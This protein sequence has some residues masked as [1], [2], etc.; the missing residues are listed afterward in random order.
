M[1]DGTDG[2][3]LGAAVPAVIR[4]SFGELLT[5]A[6]KGVRTEHGGEPIWSG[7]QRSNLGNNDFAAECHGRGA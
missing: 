4:N 6:S 2:L 5:M 7:N 1:E 3:G